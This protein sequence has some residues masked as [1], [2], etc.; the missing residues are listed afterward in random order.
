VLSAPTVAR[1]LELLKLASRAPLP[2]GKRLAAFSSSGGDNGMAA[3]FASAAGPDLPQPTE[4]P[5]DAIKAMLPDHA[6]G[7]N[8]P[9]LT[10]GYWGAEDKLTP[11]FRT[12][13]GEGGYDLALIVLDHPRP[14]LGPE[15]VKALEAMVRALGTASRETGVIGG[16]A[17]VD[18]LSMPESM[19]HYALEEGRMPL[20]G[21]DDACAVLACWAAYAAFQRRLECEGPPALPPVLAPIQAGPRRP[22][23]QPG[24]Q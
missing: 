17:S 20:Q 5:R 21:L 15:P 11:M 4:R 9:D 24:S 14:E 12:M 7:S 13:L 19:R 10:A 3:D 8:P 1:F 2:K 16:L 18:A 6:P 22:P 23:D